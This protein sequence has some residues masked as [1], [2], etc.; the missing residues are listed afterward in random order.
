MT[1]EAK[2]E[3]TKIRETFVGAAQAAYDATNEL[4][5]SATKHNHSTEKKK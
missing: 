3:L 4:T 2:K 5:G 1:D